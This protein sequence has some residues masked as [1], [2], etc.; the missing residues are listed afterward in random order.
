MGF[1]SRAPSPGLVGCSMHAVDSG[2]MCQMLWGTPCLLFFTRKQRGQINSG[3]YMARI[4]L[5]W[6]GPYS[7]RCLVITSYYSYS[8][9]LQLFLG[10]RAVTRELAVI[11]SNS[12]S[13]PIGAT[14]TLSSSLDRFGNRSTNG[15]SSCSPKVHRSL[16]MGFEHISDSRICAPNHC[17]RSVGSW[18]RI[19]PCCPDWSQICDPPPAS[20]FWVLQLTAHQTITSANVRICIAS[21]F[22]SALPVSSFLAAFSFPLARVPL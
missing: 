15:V 7:G 3:G 12:F 5:A 8:M 19:S 22:T 10:V 16:M 11:L 13:V 18:G 1:T 9:L 6:M 21:A 20:A 14:A 17:A 4:V 2:K